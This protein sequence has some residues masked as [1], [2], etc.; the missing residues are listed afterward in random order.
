MR[1]LPYAII[2]ILMVA[3]SASGNI[4]RGANELMLSG[5][6]GWMR[7]DDEEST[8][9]HL[10]AG[11]GTFVSSLVEIGSRISFMLN[12]PGDTFGSL[13]ALVLFY[14]GS[15]SIRNIRSYAGLQLGIGLGS[16][17][18]PLIY[19]GQMGSKYYLSE[20]GTVFS[21]LYY[22]RHEYDLGGCNEYGL[23]I[24]LSVLF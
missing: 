5:A 13:S 24:G 19:G 20:G 2:G 1:K 17:D 7:C 9:Y 22:L 15:W 23:S 8:N 10:V 14:P 21:E 16:G 18:N 11:F 6:V 12:D 3:S 4:E